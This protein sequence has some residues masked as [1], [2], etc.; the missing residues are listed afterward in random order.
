M[1]LITWPAKRGINRGGGVACLRFFIFIT[2][3]CLENARNLVNV[4]NKE[5]LLIKIDIPESL[6]NC[7]LAD[8]TQTDSYNEYEILACN[9]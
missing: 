8:M 6:Y 1:P 7:I 4:I 9:F 3:D 2:S 5:R